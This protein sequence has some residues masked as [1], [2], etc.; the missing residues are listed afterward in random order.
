MT[1]EVQDLVTY[2]GKTQILHNVSLAAD[3]GQVTCLL[4]RNG[5]GKSTTLKSIMGLVS[6][7]AG[8]IRLKGRD[9]RGLPP[10]LIARAGIGYV[11]QDRRIFPTLTVRENL[12]MGM[13][14]GSRPSEGRWSIEDVLAYFPPLERRLTSKGR[15]LSGGEQQMLSVARALMGSPEVL[16]LDEPTEGLAP[17]IVEALEGV[18]REI[19]GHGVA[20]LFVESKLSVALRLARRVYVIWKGQIVYEGSPGDLERDRN[21]RQQYLEV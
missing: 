1:L 14:P 3:A 2:Y 20:V 10:Y 7:Q 19:T 21:I 13:K 15:V 6:T 8:G 4:G 16:L 17:R 9:V 12:M 5:F 11:P 18:I